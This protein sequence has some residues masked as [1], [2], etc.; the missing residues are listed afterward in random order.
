MQQAVEINV[1]G[2][3]LRGMLH[4][5]DHIKNNLPIVVIYHGFGGNK[6]GPHFIFVKLSRMLESKGIAS[7]RFDFSG[8]GESD[9]DFVNM[10]LS[11]E[12]AEANA[13]LEY[14]KSLS[15]VDRSRTSVLGFSMGGAVASV[16]AGTRTE[17]IHSLCL[18]APAGNIAEIVLHD[19]IGKDENLLRQNG[20]F[21]FEGNTMGDRFVDEL[22]EIDI[23]GQAAKYSGNVLI[24]HGG[25][26]EVVPLSSSEKY[27]NIYGDTVKFRVINGGNHIFEKKSAQDEVLELTYK[28]FEKELTLIE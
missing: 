23:Y 14:A 28:F 7:I 5:P 26:D 11:G 25:D 16:L 24:L 2:R 17:D 8:S 1:H 27:K 13:V 22:Q 12:L 9:G 18:W 4:I 10:T 21:T 6:M 3:T 20:Y 19:W 15:F